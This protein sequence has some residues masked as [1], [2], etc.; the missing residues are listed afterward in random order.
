MSVAHHS[1]R[2]ARSHWRIRKNQRWQALFVVLLVAAY[3]P[4]LFEHVRR[5]MSQDYFQFSPV[6]IAATFWLVCVRLRET[7]AA[8]WNE[9]RIEPVML[10]FSML[11]LGAAGVLNSPWLAA[12][13]FFGFGDSLLNGFPAARRSWRVLAI[14]V[15]LPLG[16]DTWIV[17]ELQRLSSSY[18]STM[19]D[20]LSIF[21]VMHGNVL[22]V[23]DRQ[24][25]VEEAC[26]GITS[27][28]LLLAGTWFAVAWL[29][30]RLLRAVPLILS[31]VWWA[32]VANV[33][34]I[35][36]IAIALERWETDLTSGVA[37]EVTGLV[38]LLVSFGMILLTKLWI[39]FLF[40]PVVNASVC[41]E[42]GHRQTLTPQILWNLFTI[43]ASN[44][45]RRLKQSLPLGVKAQS[46]TLI[47][48]TCFAMLI[49]VVLR[50]TAPSL[51]RLLVG[52]V[53]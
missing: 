26:S 44:L 38:V 48:S 21:H 25:L 19:L 41:I 46:L 50:S 9:L 32:V 29:Q 35:T 15:P 1:Q 7:G 33:A 31:V 4:F 6:L 23:T 13:S 30:M 22:E 28:Y 53:K 42:D 16:Y 49:A 20:W 27:V 24:L 52:G 8:A 14:L 11:L 3:G 2:S 40:A 39:D 51:I 5:L 45:P 43:P 36:I 12:S 47:R 37:H 18:A 34:R 10:W 17:H